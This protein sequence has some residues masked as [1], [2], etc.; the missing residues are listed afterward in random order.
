M[1]DKQ[2][3]PFRG[4]QYTAAQSA[5]MDR[6][7]DRAKAQQGHLVAAKHGIGYDPAT[8]KFKQ[9]PISMSGEAFA[10][11]A[12]R[13]ERELRT[14]EQQPVVRNDARAKLEEAR[15]AWRTSGGAADDRVKAI[16]E[17][18]IKDV[19]AAKA[20]GASVDAQ[21]KILIK[22]AEDIKAAASPGSLM[23]MQRDMGSKEG[24]ARQ[25]VLSAADKQVKAARAYEQA[26]LEAARRG[27][28]AAVESNTAAATEMYRQAD[29]IRQRAEASA[30]MSQAARDRLSYD[31]GALGAEHRA[32]VVSGELSKAADRRAAGLAPDL[33]HLKKENAIPARVSNVPE[34]GK[35]D[36]DR[37]VPGKVYNL[38][39]FA[40]GEKSIAKGNTWAE[41]EVKNYSKVKV[42]RPE[43]ELSRIDRLKLAIADRA[44]G[45]TKAEAARVR[46][47]ANARARRDVYKSLGMKKGKYGDY[48]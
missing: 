27:D 35:G 34:G 36:F 28:H 21:R 16:G 26:A 32:Q 47:N 24:A 7:H 13:A 46:R 10:L 5:A 19:A 30:P 17:K 2:G 4:N 38:T 42:D 33:D 43:P 25:R 37:P 3:H 39:G 23:G 9:G 12:V 1:G 40:S 45:V 41:S 44:I 8:G 14:G 15:D 18:A 11:R 31:A 6:M 29:E 48:E 20:R 22:A